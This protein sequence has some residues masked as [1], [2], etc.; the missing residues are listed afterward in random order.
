MK[1]IIEMIGAFSLILV[2]WAGLSAVAIYGYRKIEEYI[3]RSQG[4][5][6]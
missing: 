2:L 4:V 3:E 6:V 1:L 5:E